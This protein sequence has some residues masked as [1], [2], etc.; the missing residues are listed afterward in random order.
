MGYITIV[1]VLNC[2]NQQMCSEQMMAKPDVQEIV[3]S[4]KDEITF[5]QSLPIDFG[6]EEK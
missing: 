5:E 4:S 3:T 1:L 6:K 2:A